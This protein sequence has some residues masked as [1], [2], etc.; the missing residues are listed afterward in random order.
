MV[1]M[2]SQTGL[3]VACLLDLLVGDPEWSFHPVRILGKTIDYLERLLRRIAP[4][5]LSQTTAGIVLCL[6]TVTFAYGMTIAI[7]YLASMVNWYAGVLITILF[8][9][10]TISIKSLGDAAGHVRICPVSYTHLTLPTN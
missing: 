2:M 4:S 1:E 5:I 9:Y 3:L 6:V 7:I 8:A 10:F